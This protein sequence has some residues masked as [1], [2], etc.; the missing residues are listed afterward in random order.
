MRFN[1][2]SILC[3]LAFT[4][5]SVAETESEPTPKPSKSLL[6]ELTDH[7]LK[8]LFV[9]T[10]LSYGR[11]NFSV[12]SSIDDDSYDDD[13]SEAIAALSGTSGHLT[14]RIGY[15]FSQRAGFYIEIK[16]VDINPTFG[17]LIFR[18]KSPNQYGRLFV[19]YLSLGVDDPALKLADE[20]KI[21]DLKSW[22]FGI[23]GG[24][25]FHR[26]LS[27]EGTI[28]YSRLSFPVEYQEVHSDG[29]DWYTETKEASIYLNRLMIY[30]SVIYTFY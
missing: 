7:N 18:T 3:L 20:K 9:A 1:L 12:S 5:N 29:W 2:L 19:G 6:D 4:V 22:N 13:D 10:G 14:S 17:L 30:A 28:E 21:S 16:E 23:G 15:G 26:R 27:L 8:G 24:L 25:E 11:T